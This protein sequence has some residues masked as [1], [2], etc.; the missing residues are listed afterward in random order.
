MLSRSLVKTFASA[1]LLVEYRY[2]S[3]PLV[4][5]TNGTPSSMSPSDISKTELSHSLISVDS[6]VAA[7]DLPAVFCNHLP[8]P[9]T[10]TDISDENNTGR[11]TANNTYETRKAYNLY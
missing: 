9:N 7:F 4:T 3:H 1:V 2:F 10:E 11:I 8:S 6:A 5:L